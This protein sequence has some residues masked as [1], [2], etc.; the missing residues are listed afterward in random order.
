MHTTA[1]PSCAPGLE[2]LLRPVADLVLDPANARSH[3]ERNLAAIRDS[4]ARFG[5]QKPIVVA[6]DG[7]VLAGN[8]TRAP[9]TATGRRLASSARTRRAG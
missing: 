8:G 7:T 2:P 4:L 1:S 3:D 5:Q 6:A 9:S